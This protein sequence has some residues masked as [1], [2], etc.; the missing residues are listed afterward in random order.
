MN[1]VVMETSIA[2]PRAAVWD[3]M[4]D[5]R[6]PRFYVSGVTS[7]EFNPG[8]HE[9]VG[10]SRKV[11]MTRQSSVDET[12]IAWEEGR[13]FTLKIHNGEKQVAPFK[14]ATIQYAIDDA[15]GEHTRFRATFAYEM[16]GGMFGRIL[17]VCLVRP[18]LRRRDATLGPNMKRYYETGQIMNA[19]LT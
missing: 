11:S 6:L 8:P 15:P 3:K 14:S 17:D 10:A 9:G 4:R 13:C 18:G 2:L 1:Q 16:A 12:V 5:L 19:A 7:I